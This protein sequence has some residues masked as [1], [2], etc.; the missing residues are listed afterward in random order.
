MNSFYSFHD[1]K[2]I[3]Y[4]VFEYIF[5][6]LSFFLKKEL[7]SS[8]RMDQLTSDVLGLHFLDYSI[9]STDIRISHPQTSFKVRIYIKNMKL[10]LIFYKQILI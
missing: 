6:N 9:E 5:K 4:F 10:L 8:G 1:I 2:Y 7:I 3:V